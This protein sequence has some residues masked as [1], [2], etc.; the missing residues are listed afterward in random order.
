MEAR[1]KV[2]REIARK[3]AAKA[4]IALVK[5]EL[6]NVDTIPQYPQTAVR[7]D[8][9]STELVQEKPT[10]EGTER[11]N[12]IPV[13]MRKM[14]RESHRT[15]QR[16]THVMM[17]R[18]AALASQVDTVHFPLLSSAT[19]DSP[20]M[21]EMMRPGPTLRS[22]TTTPIDSVTASSSTSPG[23]SMLLQQLTVR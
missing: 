16:G 20:L 14:N 1:K 12:R 21:Y 9:T 11:Q 4:A 10:R 7:M 15:W 18:Q 8:L 23:G 2:A 3:Q 22:M 13:A 19:D 6:R 17:D 5:E